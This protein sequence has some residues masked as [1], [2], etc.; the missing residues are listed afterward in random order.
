MY[1]MNELELGHQRRH[2]LL[3]EAEEEHLARQLRAARTKKAAWI[4]SAPLGRS[5]AL[6]DVPGDL[7]AGDRRCA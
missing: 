3:R 7:R 6:L 5:R 2:E 1:Q 4:R